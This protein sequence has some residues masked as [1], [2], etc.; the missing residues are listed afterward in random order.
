M[1]IRIITLF[2]LSLSACNFS[3]QDLSGNFTGKVVGI[4]DG[5]TFEIMLGGKAEK[6]R[7]AHIDCPEKSQPY[8]TRAKQFASDL[9]FGKE[10]IVISTERD[11]YKRII[12][13]IYL[14]DGTNVNKELVKAGLAWHYQQ[15]SDGPAY[16]ILETVARKNKKGLWSQKNV[17][18]P[19]EWRKQKKKPKKTAALY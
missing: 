19:W 11:R 8:G 17:I 15:Y 12:G 16:S 5:D 10:V 9:C 7:L 18:A 14:K 13:T 2:F 6:V 3:I 1:F 4:K